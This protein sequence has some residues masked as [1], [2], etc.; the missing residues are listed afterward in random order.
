M[1]FILF[2]IFLWIVMAIGFGGIMVYYVQAEIY[3]GQMIS[4]TDALSAQEA[5]NSTAALVDCFPY[6]DTGMCVCVCVG[7]G[8]GVCV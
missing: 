8:N 4:S 3:C 1:V 2:S 6:V 5:I 7:E